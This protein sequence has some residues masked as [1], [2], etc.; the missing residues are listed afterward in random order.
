M[1]KKPINLKY[2]TLFCFLFLLLLRAYPLDIYVSKTGNDKNKGTNKK[3]IATLEKAKELL[4]AKAGEEE[5]TVY[6]QDGIYYLSETL[7]LK[8][9]HSG[10]KGKPV[11]FKA[12]NE[13]KAIISGGSLLD[14]NW[15]EYKDGIY[16]AKTPEG[17]SICLLYTSDAADD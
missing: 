11:T 3:P 4:E 15:K 13:G 6:L 8:A 14:L 16:Q 10:A 17:L 1:K 12:I 2:P 7:V 5:V 9:T